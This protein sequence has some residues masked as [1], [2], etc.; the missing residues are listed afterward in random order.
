[1][2]FLNFALVGLVVGRLLGGRIGR[3]ADTRIVA[4]ELV[5]V[6]LG[7]QVIAF[8]FDFLP[9]TTPSILSRILWLGSFALLILMLV[10]NRTLRGALIVAAGLTCNVVAVVANG[11]L[12][13]VRPG[14]LEAAG[15]SYHVHNNSIQLGH[16][17]LS[18]LIDRW[19]VPHWLPL[20]NV[21]SVGD[22][23]IALG[24]VVAIAAAMR[25][26]SEADSAANVPLAA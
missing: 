20:G 2:V 16:P 10:L 15:T 25:G 5:F 24:T 26:S 18:L 14:A 8:P 19:A 12:M 22:V 7:L 1:M 11:G 13:P 21:F 9:W 6:A 23:L 4:R 3:L 17:H